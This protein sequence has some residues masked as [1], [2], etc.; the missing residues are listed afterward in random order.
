[1]SVSSELRRELNYTQML[2]RRCHSIRAFGSHGICINSIPSS[3]T[4]VSLLSLSSA[5]LVSS[6]PYFTLSSCRALLQFALFT[7]FSSFSP[8]IQFNSS[9][10]CRCKTAS[11]PFTESRV[12]CSHGDDVTAVGVKVPLGAHVSVLRCTQLGVTGR[13]AY[14]MLMRLEMKAILFSIPGILMQAD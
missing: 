3:R 1:M 13:P 5:T 14:D 12:F 4:E 11:V 7:N 8:F 6:C 2:D 10:E 9:F